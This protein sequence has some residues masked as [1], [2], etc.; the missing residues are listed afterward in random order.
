[1]SPWIININLAFIQKTLKVSGP[2]CLRPEDGG[3]WLWYLLVNLYI[4]ITISSCYDSIPLNWGL[5]GR[6]GGLSTL[7]SWLWVCL[8]AEGAKNV[9]L[10]CLSPLW[11][12]GILTMAFTHKFVYIY[13]YIYI[14]ICIYIYTIYI[15]NF[16]KHISNLN[17]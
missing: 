11:G 5:I 6:D 9:S 10:P 17:K 7:V 16:N 15:T 2:G 13:I 3:V 8:S 14:Y 1:M 4:L 12:W